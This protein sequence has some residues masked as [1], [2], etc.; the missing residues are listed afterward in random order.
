MTPLQMIITAAKTVSRASTALSG[1]PASIIETMSEISITVTAR[2][3]I[4]V[5]SGSPTLWATTSAWWTAASTAA[6]S[7]SPQ[8][9]EKA[10][11]G[12]MMAARPSS[13]AATRG[14]AVDQCR[15]R[16]P[17]AFAMGAGPYL[18]SWRSGSPRRQSSSWSS[19]P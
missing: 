15:M 19:S 4:S 3:R 13:A 12:G 2:A 17:G 7:A 14:A 8:N 10:P 16:P 11:L 1:P 5:P 6:M 9:A 18:S